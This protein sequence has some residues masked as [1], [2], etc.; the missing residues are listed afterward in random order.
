[1]LRWNGKRVEGSTVECLPV[2]AD[3]MPALVDRG[4]QDFLTAVRVATEPRVAPILARTRRRL[5][6]EDL[7]LFIAEAMRR[8]VSADVAVTNIGGVRTQLGPGTIRVGDVYEVVPFENSL[9]TA[10]LT[11]EQLRRFL[12]SNATEARQR[13]L[14]ACRGRSLECIDRGA[15]YAVVTNNFLAFGGDGF[16]GFLEGRQVA[17]LELRVRDVVQQALVDAAAEDGYLDLERV[18]TGTPPSRH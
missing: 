8:A 14:S 3:S 7:A 10:R 2:F 18:L 17:W 13:G 11:G 4:V 12:G 16:Q 1:V 6:T 15:S 9:V 5:G